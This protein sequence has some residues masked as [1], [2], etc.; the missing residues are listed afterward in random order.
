MAKISGC[1]LSVGLVL[2]AGIAVTQSTP[3]DEV[4]KD[5]TGARDLTARSGRRSEQVTPVD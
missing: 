1:F 5:A 2:L 4:T 3:E